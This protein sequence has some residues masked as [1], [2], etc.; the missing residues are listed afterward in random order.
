[1]DAIRL[2]AGA[3]KAWDIAAEEAARSKGRFIEKEHL[4]IG[5]LSLEKALATAE[6]EAS[7]A[8]KAENDALD[9][10]LEGVCSPASHTLSL[11]LR[12]TVRK[13]LEVADRSQEARVIHRSEN[14]KA[15]FRKAGELSY[16]KGE[17]TCLHLL[18]AILENPGPVIES[19]LAAVGTSAEE[20]DEPVSAWIAILEGCG[21]AF[22]HSMDKKDLPNAVNS[23]LDKNRTKRHSSYLEK[24]G[25]DLTREAVEGR[26]GPFTGRK[27]EL[28][29]LIQVLG[30]HAKNNPVLVGESG[31]GKTAIVEALAIRIARGK[32]FHVLGGRRLVE[33]NMASLLANTKYRGDLEERLMGIL[34][35]AQADKNIILFIDEIHTIVGAGRSDGA[36]M[37]AAGIFKPYLARGLRCIGASTMSEYH[38]YIGADAAL[39]RRFETI[40]VEEPC[41]EEA[42][43]MLQAVR[44]RLEEYHGVRIIDTALEAAVD[45]SMRFDAEHM[46]PDKAVDLI[47]TA[48]AGARI[49]FAEHGLDGSASK[50]SGPY[51]GR[52]DDGYQG[53]AAA[54]ASR[55]PPGKHVFLAAARA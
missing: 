35:E 43:D 29:Q 39:E 6:G 15:V 26:L 20:M 12:R 9:N 37:D 5:V 31:V 45:L 3:S 21:K 55:R 10:V 34:E 4:L 42:L 30:R 44:P 47:D 8:M 1:M 25:R 22:D 18:A 48:C 52:R 53:G 38:R 24:Y 13:S 23:W 50:G 19:A 51:G 14:T 11:T 36:A 27:K 33:L 54:R 46:L 16:S 7:R 28:L 49:P 17:I 2:S 32:D 41:R 40:L